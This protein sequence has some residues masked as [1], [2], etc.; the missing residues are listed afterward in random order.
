MSSSS[1][2]LSLSSI[3]IFGVFYSYAFEAEE[4]KRERRLCRDEDG[5]H[6]LE[7]PLV[8]SSLV[9]VRFHSFSLYLSLSLTPSLPLSRN[10][11]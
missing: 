8:F 3:Y 5:T 2:T 6:R 10:Y 7:I 1:L 9:N 11:I 4:G